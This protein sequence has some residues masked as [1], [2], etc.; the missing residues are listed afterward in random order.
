MPNLDGVANLYIHG[1][2]A[3]GA[4]PGA[5]KGRGMLQNGT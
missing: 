4:E 1:L 3:V 2:G 5:T